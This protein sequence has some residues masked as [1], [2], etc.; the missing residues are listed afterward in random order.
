MANKASGGAVLWKQPMTVE[1]VVNGVYGPTYRPT[2]P[3]NDNV[4]HRDAFKLP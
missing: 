4:S 3:P 2:D 1:I